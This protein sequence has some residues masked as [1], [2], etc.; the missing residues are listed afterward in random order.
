MFIA[1]ATSQRPDGDGPGVS[2]PSRF[3]GDRNCGASSSVDAGTRGRMAEYLRVLH[4][5]ENRR[6][7]C[8]FPDRGGWFVRWSHQA[9]KTERLASRGN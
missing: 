2:G 1:T 8:G 3:H 4:F 5:K 9:K 6:F 7:G